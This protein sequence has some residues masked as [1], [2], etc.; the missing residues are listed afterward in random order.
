MSGPI[1]QSQFLSNMGLEVRM[2][3]LLLQVATEEDA[4]SL[5]DSFH[6]L[7]APEQMGTSYKVMSFHN[8]GGADWHAGFSQSD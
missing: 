1:N 8:L 3:R 7:V 6:R 2:A 4:Q 5:I